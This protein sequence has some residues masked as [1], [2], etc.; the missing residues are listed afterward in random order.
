MGDFYTSLGFVDS[1][2]SV[3]IAACCC[4]RGFRISP[5]TPCT[6][7]LRVAFVCH[8][9]RS[10]LGRCKD[11]PKYAVLFNPSDHLQH[12]ISL[13]TCRN[14]LVHVRFAGYIP[15][16]LRSSLPRQL[17]NKNCGNMRS[18]DSNIPQRPLN[19]MYSTS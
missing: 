19:G 16:Q 10:Y 9:S 4:N 5:L 8:Y 12:V 18:R 15:E 17:T 11:L 6:K 13:T 1:P 3:V 2:G 14:T 7:S